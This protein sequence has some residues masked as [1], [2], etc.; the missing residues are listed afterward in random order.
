MVRRSKCKLFKIA[1]ENN[2]VTYILKDVDVKDFY[3]MIC[4]NN[5]SEEAKRIK[6]I[7]YEKSRGDSYVHYIYGS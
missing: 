1:L 5:N 2:Q 6:E 7:I 3:R 4:K